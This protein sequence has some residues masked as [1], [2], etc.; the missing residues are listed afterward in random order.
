MP[1]PSETSGRPLASTT[2]QQQQSEAN[3][4]QQPPSAHSGPELNFPS[5]GR[6]PHTKKTIKARR[7]PGSDLQAPSKQHPGSSRSKQR[8]TASPSNMAS[9]PSSVNY[10]KTGRISKAKKGLKVHNCEKCGR[11]YTRAEHLRRHQ[12][13]HAQ[14]GA[15][16]CEY[17]NCDKT[18]FRIDLLQRHQ[19]R[20]NDP[21]RVSRH[22][23]EFTPEGSPELRQTS[24][25]REVTNHNEGTL[26]ANPSFDTPQPASPIHESPILTRYTSNPFRTPQLPRTFHVPTSTFNHVIHSSPNFMSWN[27]RKHH[28]SNTNNNSTQISMPVDGTTPG[29]WPDIHSQSPGYSSSDGYP[30]PNPVSGDYGNMFPH[31]SYC[32]EPTRTRASSNAS[33]IEPPWSYISHSPASATSTMVYPCMSNEKASN[34]PSLAYIGASYPMM[35][36]PTTSSVDPM[37]G[38]GHYDPKSMLQRDEEESVILFGE[39][40][41]GMGPIAH[42]YPFEQDLDCYWR[43]F[44]P[45]FPI[46]H[47]PTFRR[48]TASPMLRAAMIA[49]GGQYSSDASVKRKSRVLHDRCVKLLERRQ[50][51][52]MTEP[53]RLMDHQ[54]IFLIEFLSQFR[55]RR[56]SKVL[57]GHFVKVYLESV[58]DFKHITSCITELVSPF[59]QSEDTTP[60]QWERWVELTSWQRLLQACYI[61]ESHQGLFLARETIP[62]LIQATGY[63]LPFPIPQAVW[64]ADSLDEWKSTSQHYISVFQYVYEVNPDLISTPLDSFQSSMLLAAHYNRFEV[65]APYTSQPPAFDLD[66]CLDTSLSMVR[67]HLTAKLVHVTPIRALLAIPGESWI[68][69]EKVPIQAFAGLKTTLRTWVAQ[70]Y[71]PDSTLSRPTPIKTALQLSISILEAALKEQQNPVMPEIGADLSIFFAALVLWA[72]TTAATSRFEDSHQ[73]SPVSFKRYPYHRQ[74]SSTLPSTSRAP[75]SITS[76][77][78]TPLYSSLDQTT[79][80]SNPGPHLSSMSFINIPITTPPIPQSPHNTISSLSHAQITINTITFLSTVQSDYTD[81]ALQAWNAGDLARC[82]TGCVSLLLWVKL[83]LH[84]VSLEDGVVRGGTSMRNTAEGLGELMDG[85]TNVIEK[86]LGRGW[87]GWGI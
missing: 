37:T 81:T 14:D 54:A 57:T 69:S 21:G 66:D 53:E 82:Q 2:L 44:H 59:G 28:G 67:Q 56:S 18:F 10:T 13:N 34:A 38:Y 11:A 12:K 50:Q 60:D 64:E 20:H 46:I 77:P 33:L 41:Y 42:T 15:L 68:F 76:S 30:S 1:E 40:P 75:S 47:R 65:G 85:V 55:A 8:S 16:V 29:L 19:E 4:V 31:I 35:G 80:R 49:V 17:P 22:A 24:G 52:T 84:G 58:V 63:D 45:A 6:Q 51:V 25:P 9:S 5:P 26:A 27:Q 48:L 78:Q 32:T 74:P 61:L 62:S 71:T 3:T 36:I 86:I 72:I 73:R 23:S 79:L 87:R 7:R 43:L 39:H 70:L 83:R